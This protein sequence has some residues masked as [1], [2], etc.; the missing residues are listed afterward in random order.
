VRKAPGPLPRPAMG[1]STRFAGAMLVVLLPALA[2]L[3]A[4]ARAWGAPAP[5]QRTVSNV[6]TIQWDE[7]GARL[8]KASNQVD[9]AVAVPAKNYS[10]TAYRFSA[11]SGS[12][13]VN[14]PVPQC[15]ATTGTVPAALAAAWQNLSLAPAMLTPVT[16]IHAGEPL[17]VVLDYP[18]G[19]RD[20]NTVES[21]TGAVV[22]R[23]GDREVLTV[24]ETGPDTGKFAGYIQTVPAPPPGVSGDC[25]LTVEA[26]D[27]IV[28]ESLRSGTQTPLASASVDVLVDPF[29]IA[30]DSVDA[31]PVDGTRITLVDAATGQPATVFGDD[32]TSSY[33]ATIVTGG[34]VRDGSGNLYS[35]P[36]GEYRF[37]FVRAGTYRLQVEP[38]KPYAAPS[39]RTPADLAGLK[40]PDGQAFTLAPASYGG[41]ITLSDTAPV[42]LDIPLDPPAAPIQLVKSA[43]VRDAGPGELVSYQVDVRNPDAHLPTGKLT[44]SD[45][46]G[47]AMRL[48]AGTIRVDGAS[49]PATVASDGTGFDVTLAPLAPGAVAHVRYA[50]EVR[51]DAKEGD[52]VN[53]A[54][55]HDDH[56][57]SSNDADAAVRIHRD[58][59][60]SRLTI[61]GRVVDG[62]C[63]VE[64]RG[65]A[66]VRVM[67]ED[68]S[69]AVTDPDGR[70]HF[71]GIVPGTHVV[72]VDDATLPAD[73]ALTDC[74]HDTRSG[75]R[76]FSRFVEGEGG[77]LK[78]VD[79]HAVP[80]A[81]RGS[82]AA[83]A[84]HRPE[85]PT[86]A[87]AA[88]AE[89]DW[90][91]G[92][93]PGVA[94]LFPAVDH[95]PRAPVVRVAIKHLPGQTVKLVSGAH[96]VDAVAFD[97][98]RKNEAGTVAV[99]LWRAIPLA[100]GATDFTAEVRN[101]DGSLAQTLTRTVH[102]GS[103]PM[104]AE[105]LRDRSVLVADGVTRP[106]IAVRLTDRD[107][108]PV[109]HGLV[110]DFELPSPY[111][112]A[113]EA[114]AQ[115]APAPSGASRA[116]TESP[117]SSSSRPPPRA[118]SACASTSRRARPSASSAS[119]HGSTPASVPGRSS[120]SPRALSATTASAA[121]WKG[122]RA[123]KTRS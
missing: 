52:A 3:H 72:Q 96:P 111:Y 24:F 101:S 25:K 119:R 65:I 44:V 114:D 37:P 22:A 66:G 29:G 86:D 28:V 112:P 89:R 57:H 76:A 5:E 82:P 110:G 6:A 103:S 68:G 74:A 43:S 16:E 33:P 42:R 98:T 62:A 97:G 69:Y 30:F 47:I 78:R 115:Q 88:G 85:I 20:P 108:R 60:S 79:F 10:L 121:G 46:F 92:Q 80:S 109:R 118:A 12:V 105:L 34:S 75:G 54:S 8:S 99:S 73:R 123:R 122:S 32:G 21:V 45:R 58:E 83:A 51:A 4:P 48:R 84:S 117:I 90:L 19:N 77:A 61:E 70:Y 94:W 59:I 120:A 63:G 13:P 104:Q 49:V 100:E 106:I 23:S 93:Q 64:G 71:E 102:Y 9:I 15:S 27:K 11:N 14:V 2:A 95:N 40:R 31:K 39:T 67:L 81:P 17:L 26:G 41:T 53:R 107:G 36:T 50:L 116:T 35:F 7:G 1:R 87:A 91:A 56:G 38:A 113:A 18:D 55:A